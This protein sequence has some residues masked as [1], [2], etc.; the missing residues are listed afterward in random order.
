MVSERINLHNYTNFN[1]MVP[2]VTPTEKEVSVG[3]AI[4]ESLLSSFKGTDRQFNRSV[5][6]LMSLYALFMTGCYVY[7]YFLYFPKVISEF[8]YSMSNSHIKFQ[9]SESFWCNK[10]FLICFCEIT[11]FL[12]F[13]DWYSTYS[14]EVFLGKDIRKQKL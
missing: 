4:Q 13:Y 2:R 9:Y 11:N 10:A 14:N 7:V 1:P 12:Y 8:V 3:E 6:W 5:I